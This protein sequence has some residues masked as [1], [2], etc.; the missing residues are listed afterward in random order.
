MSLSIHQVQCK[1]LIPSLLY[2][3]TEPLV[4]SGFNYTR[5]YHGTNTTTLTFDWDPP[6]GS[7]SETIVDNY[8]LSISPSPPPNIMVPSPPGTVTLDHNIMYSINITA[9]N[10]AGEGGSYAFPDIEYSKPCMEILRLVS[11]RCLRCVSRTPQRSTIITNG[12]SFHGN[13][14]PVLLW[15]VL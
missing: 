11:V 9:E 14:T 8:T 12:S 7:G 13:V 10:C 3:F 6:Q 4:P 2:N 1:V 5:E 15:G